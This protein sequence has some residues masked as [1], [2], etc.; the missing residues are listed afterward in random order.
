[1]PHPR[2]KPQNLAYTSEADVLY[3]GGAAGGGKSDLLLG[4]AITD[5]QKSI[6][7][8]R[9]YKQLRELEDRSRT[10][11][12]G[13]Q[14]HYSKTATRWEDLPGG[15][16]LEFGAVQREDD[17][18]NFKG[19]PH[20]LVGFD[21]VPDFTET[22]FRFLMA[23]NRSTDPNQ[24]CRVVATGN[25]PTTPEGRWVVGYWAPWISRNHPRPASPGE[26]RWFAVID[27]K[28]VEVEGPEPFMHNRELIIP[29]SR[30]F[31]PAFLDDNPYFDGTSYKSQLQALPE[32][33]RSQ[34]LYGDFLLE[35]EPQLRQVIP[36]QWV[37]EAQ[38]RWRPDDPRAS[39]AYTDVGI[40]PSRGGRDK[41]VIAPR[42]GTY[43]HELVE[44]EGRDVPDGQT[45]ATL[46]I[47][48]VGREFEG[49][50]RIDIIGIGSSAY[51]MLVEA[52]MN[53][54][55][56]NFAEKSYATDSSGKIQMRNRRAEG[57]WSLREALDPK[58]GSS[59]SL[60]H[61][62]ELVA[63]LTA[64][65]W[66]RTTRGITVE[67]KKQVRDRLGRSPDKGDAAVL[68][69]IEA[70]SGVFFS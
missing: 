62:E 51:D 41:T 49:L 38:N 27:G 20:D 22:Q 10:I 29:R 7:F 13:T 11:L 17:K 65:T 43:F 8:R 60:P 23:W 6:I 55:D 64:P 61:D 57:Y 15:G 24:R 33:L 39:M 36:T 25:P 34:L 9:E 3:F 18:A 58:T 54:A 45:C 56:I 37:R 69:W 2:N 59:I 31:I 67:S 44:F 42:T 66:V 46:V 5:H 50:L 47:E 16:I 12:E 26:L 48:Q 35:E 63:D 19:R 70:A 30:S 32:P 53:I 14:A 68:S 1:M 21:E 4:L 40:D 28:D 52:D